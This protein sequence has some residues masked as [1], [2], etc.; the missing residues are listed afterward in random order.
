MVTAT[1]LDDQRTVWVPRL[2]DWA[3]IQAAE[4]LVQAADCRSKGYV[5]NAESF[6][7]TAKRYRHVA[8]RARVL[9]VD[10]RDVHEHEPPAGLADLMRADEPPCRLVLLV[11]WLQAKLGRWLPWVRTESWQMIATQV[12]MDRERA[13]GRLP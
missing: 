4:Y 8:D 2:I 12:L 3:N 7:A 11:D 10:M 9:L 13:A 5:R 1:T 6:V